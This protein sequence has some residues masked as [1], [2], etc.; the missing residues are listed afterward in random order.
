M[1]INRMKAIQ[2]AIREPEE[3]PQEEPKK[4]APNMEEIIN[5]ITQ[6]VVTELK[7]DLEKKMAA[8][9]QQITTEMQDIRRNIPQPQTYEQQ[10]TENPQPPTENPQPPQQNLI[11]QLL[12]IIQL[13]LR[14][15]PVNPQNQEL[16]NV[17]NQAMVRNQLAK[18][19]TADFR[20]LPPMER[21]GMLDKRFAT[22]A[23]KRQGFKSLT[24]QQERLDEIKKPKE[25]WD[26][27]APDKPMDFTKSY[28]GETK[29][30]ATRKMK[31]GVLN[32]MKKALELSPK[33]YAKL[34][35]T[36]RNALYTFV[37]EFP[38]GPK[39]AAEAI[40]K[41]ASKE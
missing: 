3:A 18:M 14:P 5:A 8:L 31:R 13:F 39:N 37:R 32:F 16:M 20:K 25:W 28:R 11:E 41:G 22:A 33:E 24:K 2:E 34:K 35:P 1:A 4:E 17:F 15:A 7:P 23:P 12:P 19:N 6:K 10:P 21:L 9:S 36:E 26:T 40:I 29:G 38:G 27:G 30:Q